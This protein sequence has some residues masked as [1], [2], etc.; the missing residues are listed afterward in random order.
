MMSRILYTTGKTLSTP[1]LP[2]A[3]SNGCQMGS[4][5]HSRMPAKQ[6]LQKS[7]TRTRT[8]ADVRKAGKAP[9]RVSAPG[10]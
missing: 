6:S 9:W 4:F 3:I 7:S 2:C 10:R 8:S 1:E 5:M